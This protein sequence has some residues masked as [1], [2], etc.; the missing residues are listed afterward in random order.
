M[1][2]Q[3]AVLEVASRGADSVYQFLERTAMPAD[4]GV[5]WK[6]SGTA[7]SQIC[8]G[9]CLLEGVS[10]I[11]FFLSDYFKSREIEKARDLSLA[12]SAVEFLRLS[13]SSSFGPRSRMVWHRN[14]L[15]KI[16]RVYGFC[17]WDR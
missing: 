8:G 10:G 17:H 11:S 6:S 13:K 7:A 16:L 14:G 1:I 4:E 3:P 15:A 12:A 5:R 9:R 2:Q